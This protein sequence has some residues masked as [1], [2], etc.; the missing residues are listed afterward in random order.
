[1]KTAMVVGL[2]V[3]ATLAVLAVGNRVAPDTMATILTGK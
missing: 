2:S 3:V 1:M